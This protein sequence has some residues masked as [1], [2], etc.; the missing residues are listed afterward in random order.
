MEAFKRQARKLLSEGKSIEE[1]ANMFN[2]TP[3][4]VKEEYSKKKRIQNS[5][6]LWAMWKVSVPWRR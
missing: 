6:R 3:E 2:V 1:V 5:G 4:R